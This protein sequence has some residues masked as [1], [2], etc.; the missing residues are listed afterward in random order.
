[1]IGRVLIGAA[2]LVFPAAFVSAFAQTIA[3][4]AV[5]LLAAERQTYGEAMAWYEAEARR[6][7]PRAE[8]LLGYMYETGVRADPDP[9]RARAWYEKAA[10]QGS[11]RAA[12]RLARLYQEGRGGP[13]DMNAALRFY[14][15]AAERG[16]VAAQSMLGYL[17]AAGEDVPR[18]DAEAYLWLTL[19]ARA[20]DRTAA[21]NRARLLEYLTPEARKAGEK[22][23][24]DFRPK[25]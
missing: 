11:A 14:R 6:G 9:A 3:P 13:V 12:F 5:G 7:N 4:G 23:V 20:G 2:L 10:R 8:F 16:H 25:G 15:L 19:A 21:E 17:L 24:Q 1:V 18:D 22:L